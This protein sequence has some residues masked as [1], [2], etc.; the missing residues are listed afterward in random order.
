M[1]LKFAPEA[2]ERLS[3][4]G[5]GSTAAEAPVA[6]AASGPRFRFGMF[7][8]LVRAF[9][10][11]ENR[12]YYSIGRRVLHRDYSKGYYSRTVNIMGNIPRFRSCF[13]LRATSA[14]ST[15]VV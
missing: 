6:A 13:D 3:T 15:I 2:P 7:S 14:V 4:G 1:F 9:K 8:L 10:R 11:G 12:G 5:R